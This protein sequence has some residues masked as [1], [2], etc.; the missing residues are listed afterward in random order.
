MK[1]IQRLSRLQTCL[2]SLGVDND[3]I[4]QEIVEWYL[5]LKGSPTY[6]T[7][8]LGWALLLAQVP[9]ICAFIESWCVVG[10]GYLEEGLK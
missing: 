10:K 4:S 9:I 2:T 7:G 5:S 6:K 3:T 1:V 8:L